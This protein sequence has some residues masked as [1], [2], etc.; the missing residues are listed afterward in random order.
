MIIDPFLLPALCGGLLL[1]MA[2]GPFGCLLVWRRMAY[3]GDTLSHSALMGVGLGIVGGLSPYAGIA[4]AAV[5]VALAFSFFGRQK[6]LA[7]DTLLGIISHG[8]LALGLVLVALNMSGRNTLYALLLGDILSLDWPDVALLG[9]ISA[10]LVLILLLVWRGVLAATVHE[11]MARV[12][13]Y[14]V[15]ALFMAYNLLLALLVAG[16]IRMVGVLLVAALLIVPAAAARKLSQTPEQMAVLA[17]LIGM[18]SVAGGLAAAWVFDMPTG[19]AIV[20]VAVGAFL[21]LSLISRAP[22][23]G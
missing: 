11:D 2:A 22:L 3:F 8:S 20:L 21:V 6:L 17:S 15:D 9:G 19:P 18:I 5:I 1:A 7:N 14:P 23:R 10:L 13:G 12:D 16:A 4:L